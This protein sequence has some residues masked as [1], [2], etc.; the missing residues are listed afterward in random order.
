[1]KTILNYQPLRQ[2]GTKGLINVATKEEAK[3]YKKKLEQYHYLHRLGVKIS[4]ANRSFVFTTLNKL[5]DSEDALIKL[6][7]DGATDKEKDDL[8]E[9][10]AEQLALLTELSNIQ[11]EIIAEDLPAPRPNLKTMMM[12]EKI[13]T[14]EDGSKRYRTKRNRKFKV[15]NRRMELI[16][17]AFVLKYTEQI[18]ERKTAEKKALKAE[19]KAQEKANTFVEKVHEKKNLTK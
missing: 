6:I 8:K 7:Q 19:V 1:M 17:D 9:I 5:Q 13:E 11:D 12:F 10:I 2:Q 18:A 14:L 3:A 15:N 16:H 4:K